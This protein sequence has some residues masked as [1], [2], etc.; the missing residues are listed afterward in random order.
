MKSQARKLI[1]KKK[2]SCQ[3]QEPNLSAKVKCHA[4]IIICG[5][6]AWDDSHFIVYEICLA[7]T[8][9]NATE[10]CQFNFL[11]ASAFTFLG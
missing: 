6:N 7:T 3:S 11:Y 5:I 1:L 9:K 4:Q 2:D 8:R 10:L